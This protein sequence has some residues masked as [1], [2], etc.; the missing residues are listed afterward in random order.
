MLYSDAVVAMTRRQTG[1]SGVVPDGDWP[2]PAGWAQPDRKADKPASP[3]A[4]T[5]K[6][7]IL[8]NDEEV[9]VWLVRL[10]PAAKKKKAELIWGLTSRQ[11][12]FKTSEPELL[13]GQLRHFRNYLE[14]LFS[15]T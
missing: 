8:D 9:A 2:R 5:W 6:V 3:Y 1:L 4:G 14:L 13:R 10:D 12:D 7:V 15:P 11:A